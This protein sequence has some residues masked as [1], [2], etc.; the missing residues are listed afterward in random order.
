[1][2]SLRRH[3]VRNATFFLTVVTYQ[4]KPILLVDPELFHASWKRVELDAWA[5]LPDHF[6]VL[7]GVGDDSISDVVH[8]FKIAYWRRY[9]SRFGPGRVWQNRF[10]DH[11][12]RDQEDLNRHLDYIH[13]NP[14]HH[15]LVSGPFQYANSLAERWLARGYYQN[16]WGMRERLSIVGQFG[17]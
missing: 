17:E 2:K 13:Y 7:I 4:R 14:V 1:M 12:I 6:H 10:W 15:G 3:L 11:V 5:V 16:D 9:R 8:R